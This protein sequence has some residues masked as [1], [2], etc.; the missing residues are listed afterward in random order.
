MARVGSIL[1]FGVPSCGR[2][3]G[4]YFLGGR[5]APSN[6]SIK[7]RSSTELPGRIYEYNSEGSGLNTEI[8]RVIVWLSHGKTEHVCPGCVLTVVTFFS[9]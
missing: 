2:G 8:R 4:F 9:F 6:S 5:I 7:T 1:K 3:A